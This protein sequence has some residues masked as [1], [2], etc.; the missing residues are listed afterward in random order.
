MEF[1][2]EFLQFTSIEPPIYRLKET[3][4]LLRNGLWLSTVRTEISPVRT[5][6]CDTFSETTQS[7]RL[8]GH[9]MDVQVVRYFLSFPMKLILSQS[10]TRAKS[11]DKNTETC[12]KI[13]LEAWNASG[14]CCTSVQT[15]AISRS[16]SGHEI[17]FLLK[18]WMASG[19]MQS[20]TVRNF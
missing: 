20:W 11:Y 4:T 8:S 15:V 13:F 3:L 6:F 12:S 1:D 17:Q 10:D 2:T 7:W 19:W 5:I 18:H 9:L 16:V 14:R